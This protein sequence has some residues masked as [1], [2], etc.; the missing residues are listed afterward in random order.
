[1]IDAKKMSLMM[2][3][4]RSPEESLKRA[5]DELHPRQELNK[6]LVEYPLCT[7]SGRLLMNA[8]NAQF[9]FDSFG[10]AISS[11]FKFLKSFGLFFLVCYIVSWLFVIPIFWQGTE[12]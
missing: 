1:M 3:Q 6:E 9:E 8:S 7:D 12:D 10:I 4:L 5:L 11:Y 2:S